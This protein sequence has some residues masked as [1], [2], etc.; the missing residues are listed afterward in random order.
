MG[1]ENKIYHLINQKKSIF[2]V[3]ESD[4]GKTYFV[5]KELIPFLK[6]KRLASTYFSDCDHIKVVPKTGVVII[7]EVETF[8]DK[9]FLEKIRATEKSYYS[10]RYIQKVNRWFKKLKRVKVPSIYIITRNSKNEIEHFQKT[11]KT[12]DWNKRVVEVVVFP[13]RITRR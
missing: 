9:E 4:S 10:K 6:S 13:R 12:A 3:G 2:L 11:V 1:L 7:D 8:Q 5:L